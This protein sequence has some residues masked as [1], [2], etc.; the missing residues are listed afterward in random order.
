M[1]ESKLFK[2]QAMK[3][4]F[5]QTWGTEVTIQQKTKKEN[6]KAT[7]LQVS[8]RIAIKK[9][10]RCNN[11]LVTSNNI[12]LPKTLNHKVLRKFV[13]GYVLFKCMTLCCD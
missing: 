6:K 4:K 3:V 11:Q 7:Y 9:K 13:L 12:N 2:I 1:D 8:K 10:K 5:G